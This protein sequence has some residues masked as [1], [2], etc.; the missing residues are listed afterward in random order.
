MEISTTAVI[1]IA[2]GLGV[3]GAM[4]HRGKEISDP[5]MDEFIDTKPILGK[6]SHMKI[7]EDI[8]EDVEEST[9]DLE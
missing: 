3:I 7:P 2:V 8:P 6:R 1:G 5:E 4:C 9:E